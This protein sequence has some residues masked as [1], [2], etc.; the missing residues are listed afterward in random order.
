MGICTE[1]LCMFGTMRLLFRFWAPFIYMSKGI[2]TLKPGRKDIAVYTIKVE[3]LPECCFG[4]IKSLSLW[5]DY[6]R[7]LIGAFASRL[8]VK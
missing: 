3:P 6:E 8:D 2:C 4:Q 5:G 7:S 1:A